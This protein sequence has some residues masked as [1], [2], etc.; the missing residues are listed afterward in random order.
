MVEK[1][2]KGSV[3]NGYLQ[4]IEKTW[5]TYG[6]NQCKDGLKIDDMNIIGGH[7]YSNDMLLAIIQWISKEKGM[8][9]V[10]K[11]G[12]FTVKN[13]G[14]L[15]YIVRF[16]KTETMLMKAKDAYN[17]SYSQGQV[18]MKLGDHRATAI[19]KDVSEVPENCQGWIGALEALLELTHAHGTVV[20]TKCQLKGDSHCEYEITW[21]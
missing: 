2:V 6:L 17:E 5:G 10:R 12:N 3:I 16:T 13:L 11:A 15:A 1:T 8:E 21:K 4:F 14:I 9:Y 18:E 7:N 20:K 19:M